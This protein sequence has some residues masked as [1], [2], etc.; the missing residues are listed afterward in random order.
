MNDVYAIRVTRGAPE[1]NEQVN[2][3]WREEGQTQKT[4]QGSAQQV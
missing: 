2:A 3:T 1:L 4:R